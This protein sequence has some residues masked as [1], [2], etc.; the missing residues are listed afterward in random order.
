MAK[1]QAET[2]LERLDLRNLHAGLAPWLLP[3]LFTETSGTLTICVKRA[4]PALI[5]KVLGRKG[6]RF[7]GGLSDGQ[8][9]MNPTAKVVR[10]T[11]PRVDGNLFH[12]D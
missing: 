3:V 11:L 5:I 7:L 12:L 4:T 6:T 1:N 8:R 9:R 2:L 10:V